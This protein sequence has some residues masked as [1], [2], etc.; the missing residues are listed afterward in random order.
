MIG[1]SHVS[2]QFYQDR[3]HG[4]VSVPVGKAG[5]FGWIHLVIH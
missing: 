4:V 1:V 2:S 3:L 5:E